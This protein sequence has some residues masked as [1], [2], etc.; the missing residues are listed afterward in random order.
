MGMETLSKYTG[1]NDIYRKVLTPS[2]RNNFVTIPSEWYGR[3]VEVIV[4]PL[5]AANP[6][7]KKPIRYNWEETARRMHSAGEDKL[8]IPTELKNENTDWWQWEE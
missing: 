6:K 2:K 3:E 5:L 7:L 1:L 4:L 8:L